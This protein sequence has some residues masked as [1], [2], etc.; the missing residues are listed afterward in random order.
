MAKQSHFKLRKEQE[1]QVVT[2]EQLQQFAKALEVFLQQIENRHSEEEQKNFLQ[3]FL[4]TTFYANCVLPGAKT[5]QKGGAYDLVIYPTPK[6]KNIEVLIE[7][8]SSSNTAE[9][10]TP[11]DLNKKALQQLIVYYLRERITNQNKSLR[12]LI[13]TNLYTFFS[14]DAA[15]LYN[16]FYPQLEKEFQEIEAG[17][18]DIS[19][20]HD[21]YTDFASPAIDKVKT[22]LSYDYIDLREYRNDIREVLNGKENKALTKLY[23][24]FSPPHLL[25][26]TIQSDPNQL[27]RRFYNELLYLLGLEEQKGLGNKTLIARAKTPNYASLIE[28]TYVKVEL[29]FEHF[30]RREQYGTASEEQKFNIALELVITW[31]NRLLFLKLLETQLLNYNAGNSAYQ[32]LNK[33]KIRDFATLNN[34]FFAVLAI[35]VEQ[36]SGAFKERFSTVPYL[37]SSLFEE[38]EL[39]HEVKISGLESQQTLPLYKQSILKKEYDDSPEDL[40]IFDYLFAFLNAYDFGSLQEEE[41]IQSKT[42][43]N[44]SVLG[45]IFEKINGHKDGAVFTPSYIT[46]YI[47]RETIERAIIDKFNTQYNWQCVNIPQLYNQLDG[48]DKQEA[49]RLF[50]TITICDPAVGSGHFLVSALN[51]LIYLKHRLG[52]LQDASGT[53]LRRS[54]YEI[55]IVCDELLIT[56]EGAHFSYTPKNPESQRVQET[57]FSEKRDLIEHCLFGVD[58]NP[59]SVQI[60]RLRLWI[61]LLKHAYYTHE[62]S[63]QN[64]ETLPNIDLNIKCGNAVVYSLPLQGK[65]LDPDSQRIRTLTSEYY[66]TN[67]KSRK[68]EIAQEIETYNSTLKTK[69]WEE[70]KKAAQKRV[71]ECE[72]EIA[73]LSQ[74]YETSKNNEW[75]VD[76]PQKI[77]VLLSEAKEKHKQALQTL[78][79]VEK[80]RATTRT[81]EWRLEFPEVWGANGEFVGFDIV[82]GNPPYIKEY[83]NKQ[84]FA[85]FKA[86]SP[87]YIGKMDLWYGFLCV[88]LDLLRENGFLCFIATNNWTTS[89]GA[90]KMRERILEVA[91]IRSLIDFNDYMVFENASIQTMILF[92]QRHL[93]N[94]T[95]TFDYRKLL[96]GKSPVTNAIAFLENK[97]PN[98]I[99]LTPTIVPDYSSQRVWS[100]APTETEQLLSNIEKTANF[101]QN[102]EIAQ[103]IVCPQDILNRAGQ[104]KLGFGNIGDGVMVLSQ[105][106]RDAL[107]LTTNELQLLRPYYTTTEVQGYLTSQRNVRWIIYTDRKANVA[108]EKGMYPNLKRH[109]DR[110]CDIIT[111]S[112]K[113]YGLHRARNE[114]FFLGE[115]IICQRKCV[116]APS[117]SY[118]DFPTYV[119]AT[120]YVIKTERFNLKFLTGLLN[121]KLIA[122]W[123]RHKGKMQGSNFQIDKDP[124]LQIPIKSA[125]EIDKQIIEQVE[126]ILQIKRTSPDADIRIEE[127]TIDSLVYRLYGLSD[128]DIAI[129]ENSGDVAQ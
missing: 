99:V 114:A 88:G 7:V 57:L 129:I 86:T 28:Q 47:C 13:V 18:R 72:K 83:E 25:K 4:E 78:K 94:T 75:C 33:E 17:Q 36:R 118:A 107:H 103:G 123:L 65:W 97:E 122:Y 34:L 59:T 26:Q 48:V 81:F 89:T 38:T 44:A 120:F 12:H 35:P 101:L 106:E 30:T 49:N 52:I 128:S 64:L 9:M 104:E 43:I 73:T 93:C 66:E 23:K 125:K 74:R 62:S 56:A 54:D 10:I 92:L 121:S 61:E 51:E 67:N 60:C 2:S 58:I 79:E 113:P 115:K 3:R 77:R 126:R 76:D 124:L 95:Y 42:L 37:N 119:S 8:K 63:F 16:T 85:H 15:V 20:S 90:K 27:D 19:K 127:R 55:E 91:T 116:G 102:D 50:N 84:A 109:L 32:F 24:F 69:L 98:S 41:A 70:E 29:A 45:L 111:S 22:T 117:F 6:Q 46:S 96:I 87:Y 31:L 11:N 100:F 71:E 82:M 80:N 21:V 14:F 39:E 68:R 53:S 1:A 40:R 108:F 5:T 105:E 112:N 110:Y